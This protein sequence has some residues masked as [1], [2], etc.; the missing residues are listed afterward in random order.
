MDIDY[1]QNLDYGFHDNNEEPFVYLE[2]FDENL[3]ELNLNFIYP[4]KSKIINYEDVGSLLVIISDEEIVN[5]KF[6]VS[7]NSHDKVPIKIK[8]TSK[9]TNIAG[10][11][12]KH[13]T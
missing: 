11:F 12:S 3:E 9:F 6:S 5:V 1:S 8:K 4:F 2:E 10:K 13:L 7:T